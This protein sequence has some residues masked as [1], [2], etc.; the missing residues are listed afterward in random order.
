MFVVTPSTV[1]DP[2]RL[3]LTRVGS[4]MLGRGLRVI[5]RRPLFRGVFWRIVFDQAPLR[6]ILALSPFPIAMLIRPDLALGISQ[7]PLLMFAIV[8]MIES[9]FLSVSTPEKRRK[10]IAE[11]DAARGLDLLTLRARDVLARIAAG[12]GMETED[13]HLVVEQSGLA[14]VPVLTLVSVQ[15][16]QEGGRPLL[17][18][19]DDSERELLEDRLFAEGLDE[20]LLHLINL[21]DNRFLRSV[22]F[23]ARAVSAHQRLMARAGRRGAAGA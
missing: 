22:A 6:Y 19:L 17:L 10:L 4:Q 21:A 20:R 23:E 15:V 1:V 5:P 18:D 16:A 13:L 9:T 11:A 12:R 2:R 7:A 14:R 8:F 3:R